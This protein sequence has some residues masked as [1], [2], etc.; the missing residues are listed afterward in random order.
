MK[1]EA[2][3]ENAVENLKQTVISFRKNESDIGRQITDALIITRNRQQQQQTILG[4]CPVCGIGHLKIIK[5]SSSKKRF[6]GC[7]N[8]TAGKCQAT[9]PLPQNGTIKNTGK[10]CS[11][12]Q[13]PMLKVMYYPGDRRRAWKFCINSQCPSK[14]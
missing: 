11:V 5:S 12:C 14:K 1:S 9:A 8:Y 2:V 4:S 13:W 10:N 7:S 6:V 3:V